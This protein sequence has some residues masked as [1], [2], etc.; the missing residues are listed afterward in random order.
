MQCLPRAALGAHCGGLRSRWG[1][2]LEQLGDQLQ[3]ARLG[4]VVQ[5]AAGVQMER[6]AGITLGLAEQQEP[7]GGPSGRHS[8]RPILGIAPFRVVEVHQQACTAPGSSWLSLISSDRLVLA[9]CR[10][11]ESGSC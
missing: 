4:G 11:A 9:V 7:A 8:Q 6:P 3:V 2:G 5:R 1:L 10:V